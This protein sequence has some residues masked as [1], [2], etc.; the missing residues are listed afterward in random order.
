M[1]MEKVRNEMQ[2]VRGGGER[3]YGCALE[4]SYRRLKNG[5]CRPNSG[6]DK[7][8]LVS[9]N[10][11]QT[12]TLCARGDPDRLEYILFFVMTHAA[13]QY[14]RPSDVCDQLKR[15]VAVDDEE[16]ADVVLN[17]P[18]RCFVNKLVGI[19]DD[20]FSC[21]RIKHRRLRAIRSAQ[22]TNHVGPS[23]DASAHGS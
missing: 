21:S 20:H 7:R 11:S 1:Q 18:G 13:A 9:E 19:C 10:S 17:H 22:R 8:I 2:G 23:H 3:V 16:S 12:E 4:R 6:V 5:N 14:P 15:I